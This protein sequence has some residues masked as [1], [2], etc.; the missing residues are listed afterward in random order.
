MFFNKKAKPKTE[1]E[2]IKEHTKYSVEN[3]LTRNKERLAQIAA[4]LDD[5][6]ESLDYD[7]LSLATEAMILYAWLLD[8]EEGILSKLPC[9]LVLSS[10]WTLRKYR[11]KPLTFEA[12]N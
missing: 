4:I 2:I 7:R 9:G 6:A 5:N 3:H 1:Q 11:N 8:N 10:E 12:N